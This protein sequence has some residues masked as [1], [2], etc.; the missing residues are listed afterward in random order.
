MKKIILT[1]LAGLWGVAGL[2]AQTIQSVP[3]AD[4]AFGFRLLQELAK[5]QPDKNLFISAYSA[6][7]VLQMVANGAAGT[8]LAEMQSALATTGLPP[9]KVNAGN[10]SILRT[11]KKLDASVT[12][13]TANAI[14]YRQGLVVKPGF[15]K[16]NQDFFG[17]TVAPLD[18]ADPHAPEVI[19]QWASEQTHGKIQKLADGM[20]DPKMTA[21]FLV[22]AV[23]FKAKWADP[24]KPEITRNQPFYPQPD[25]S[26]TV[27]MM[28]KTGSFTYRRGTGY[29]AVRLP[30]RDERL[31]M[32]VFLPDTNSSPETLLT[33]LNGDTWQRVTRPGFAAKEGTLKLPR[34]KMEYDVDLIPALQAFGM[35]KAFDPVQADFSGIAPQLYIS[36]VRQKAF[37]EVKEEGTEAAA[38]TAV[39]IM[40]AGIPMPPKDP[41]LMIVDRPFLF[42]IED[43]QSGAILFAGVVHHPAE[44]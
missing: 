41:F 30:Y 29:Q 32:Y 21:L 9:E 28:A 8:T 13:S 25:K 18:F 34:F 10:Q 44:Q 15:L 39:G 24:F 38:A 35:K 26:V 12:L 16:Q 4:N 27:P 31:A 42:L 33:H 17:A 14:W 6:A 2:E 11:L 37:V 40:A 5:E 43:H 7:T 19:N 22:N 3:E 36:K 20:I 1:T 23:Y